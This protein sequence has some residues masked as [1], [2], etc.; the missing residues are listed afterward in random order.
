MH[1]VRRLLMFGMEVSAIAVHVGW[2]TERV[3]A[4]VRD[5][6]GAPK[7]PSV[8]A[9]RQASRRLRL[10]RVQA[11]ARA[12]YQ[13]RRQAGFCV[14]CKSPGVPVVPGKSRCALHLEALRQRMMNRRPKHPCRRCGQPFD[15]QERRGRLRYHPQ[16]RTEHERDRIRA[17]RERERRHMA[18]LRYQR[19]HRAL[20]LCLKCSAPTVPG[21]VLCVRHRRKSTKPASAQTDP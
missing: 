14:D 13:R 20:G 5:F 21:Q 11:Q 3:Q 16:C 1:A 2:P 4:L 7:H 9:R 19:R 6:A 15:E 10:P 12:R 8:V 18:T 17:P